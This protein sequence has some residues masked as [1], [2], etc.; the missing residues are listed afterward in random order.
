[1]PCR[2]LEGEEGAPGVD[3]EETVELLLGDVEE[4]DA[5]QLDTRVGDRDVDP[6][7][8]LGGF[9]EEALDVRDD[10]CQLAGCDTGGGAGQIWV[11][12]PSTRRSVPVVKVASA[13]R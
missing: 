13:A 3:G 8:T 6:P 4:I 2:R 5:D 7:E 11:W 10:A 9:G 1:V 12:P